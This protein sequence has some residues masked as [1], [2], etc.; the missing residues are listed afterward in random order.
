MV[1]QFSFTELA[2]GRQLEKIEVLICHPVNRV[3]KVSSLLLG[4]WCEEKQLLRGARANLLIFFFNY[5]Y[6]LFKGGIAVV[7]AS[8]SKSKGWLK[9]LGWRAHG[10]L[11]LFAS[12]PGSWSVHPL[13]WEF[14]CSA[15]S[16]AAPG[17]T[18]GE[19]ESESLVL[20]AE[21]RNSF[22]GEV[23]WRG[24]ENATFHISLGPFLMFPG[25]PWK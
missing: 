20:S 3:H 7:T 6:F 14:L 25:K 18:G 17:L 24:E 19:L 15:S 4:A 10:H 13:S 16:G 1:K 5:F 9:S 22:C 12:L 21:Y 8:V 11:A 2:G 23:M